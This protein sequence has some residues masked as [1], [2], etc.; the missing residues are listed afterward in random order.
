[1]PIYLEIINRAITVTFS[2]VA[3]L[4]FLSLFSVAQ[5]SVAS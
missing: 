2:L 5:G 1:M 3:H 4:K